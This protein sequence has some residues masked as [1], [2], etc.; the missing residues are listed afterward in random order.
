MTAGSTMTTHVAG[1]ASA[2]RSLTRRVSQ[3][4]RNTGMMNTACSLKANDAPMLTTL[5]TGCPASTR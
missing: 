3:K 1:K 4:S 2:C 5:S